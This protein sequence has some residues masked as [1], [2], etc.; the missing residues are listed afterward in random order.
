MSTMTPNTSETSVTFSLAELAKLEEERVREEDG[1]RARAR[2]QERHE[3]REAET[4]RRAAEAARLAAETEAR[5]KRAREEAQERVR[6][7]ARERA[8][9]DVARIEAEARVRLDAD[10][11]VRAHELA[12]LRTRT[13]A[14]RSRV[15][16]A[17]AAA[18]GLA[19]CAG[20][21]AAYGVSRHVAELEQVG[22]QLRAGQA[23]LA[24]ERE[25]A[26]TTELGA[27]DR[28]HAALRARP[29]QRDADEARAAA[30][31][32]RSVINPKS[33]D[34]DRLR[35]FGDALEALQARLD[36][37]EKLAA[38]DRRQ[39][40]LGAWAAEQR[41]GEA[42]GSARMAAARARAMCNEDGLRVYE[43]ALDQLRVAL[44]TPSATLTSRPAT[45]AAARPT[46]ICTPGDPGCCQP[47]DPGCGLNG[48]KLF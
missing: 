27:L 21:A 30:E 17:L 19:L 23:A 13:E 8:A 4:R 3:Q 14:G 37:L 47:G 33:L 36:T 26:K 48:E 32:A 31:A 22:E 11:A 38:L 42:T 7:E 34:Q 15:Q 5:A 9:V 10:N 46:K 1:R 44:A 43:G 20:G 39:A 24:Q 2:D 18:L 16:V 41:R 12:I 25:H 6:A 40:D 28:R 35:A 45:V 29:A